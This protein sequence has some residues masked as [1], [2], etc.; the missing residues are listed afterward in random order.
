MWFKWNIT[1]LLT[2]RTNLRLYF[3]TTVE[4]IKIKYFFKSVIAQKRYSNY[5]LLHIL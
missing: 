1:S 2:D 4:I 3:I 5:I